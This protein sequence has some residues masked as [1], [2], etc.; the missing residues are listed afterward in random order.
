MYQK[1]SQL[2]S[3]EVSERWNRGRSTRATTRSST[4]RAEIDGEC[5]PQ[6]STSDE[7]DETGRDAFAILDRG[8]SPGRLVS[9]LAQDLFGASCRHLAR[10]LGTREPDS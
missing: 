10:A 8:G 5:P 2:P 9:G 4:P 7:L 3:S 1:P 6:L